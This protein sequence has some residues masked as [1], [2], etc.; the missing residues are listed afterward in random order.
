MFCLLVSMKTKKLSIYFKCLGECWVSALT[1]IIDYQFQFILSRI[2]YST[3][4]LRFYAASKGILALQ[5]NF[6]SIVSFTI[7][8]LHP[9]VN[10]KY[11]VEV[12]SPARFQWIYYF[13][14]L[15]RSQKELNTDMSM[16]R[17]LNILWDQKYIKL[18]FKVRFTLLAIKKAL[19]H[20][21]DIEISWMV[22]YQ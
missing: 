4:Q 14:T 7:Q 6:I 11:L 5:W 18:Q 19:E 16:G 2:I 21:N 8:L 20:P 9:S 3:I 13:N 10:L 22:I 1:E 12:F 15:Q 17:C